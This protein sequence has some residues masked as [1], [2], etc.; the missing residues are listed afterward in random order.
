MSN[1]KT[2]NSK[3]LEEVIS[4][5]KEF[6]SYYKKGNSFLADLW[7]TSESIISLA[8]KMSRDK[9][10][11]SSTNMF[12]SVMKKQR[13]IGISE[14]STEFNNLETGEK[15]IEFTSDKP[16][17]KEEIEKKFS[18]DNITTKLSN[19]WNK[20]IGEGKYRVS[21]FIKVITLDSS[22]ELQK[23]TIL[24]ELFQYSPVVPKIKHE[25]GKYALE[26]SI[27]DAHFGKMAWDKESGESYDLEIAEERYT[28]AINYILSMVDHKTIDEII[29]PIGNDMI[30]IDSRNNETFA[31]TRQDSDSRFFK[32]IQTVKAILVKTINQL[33]EIAPVKVIV[34]S[35]N[36]DPE[37]MFMLGEIMDAYYHNDKN[38]EVNNSPK[39]RKYYQ[40]GSCGFQ[41]THGNEEKHESLGLIFAT[42]ESKLWADTKY[43]F[44]K[45]GHFH[46][47][48]KLN[49]VSIDEHQ[50]FQVQI[51]P[52]LSGSDAWHFS[53]GYNSMKQAKGFLYD[54]HQGEIAQ[55]TFN[56]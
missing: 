14:K 44:C 1:S 41:Y 45:L 22:N 23:E 9:D 4:K 26:I 27:P 16:L 15:N 31:G 35:G 5:L 24:K 19:Y 43:R 18:V 20:E 17:S 39:L 25:H 30:N 28:N 29:F 8:R 12:H 36:H 10:N 3:T 53:K 55:Y 7:G 34:V 11:I 52:S 46:K 56:V 50:G 54:K 48:K 32:I 13:S 2:P 37:S 21:A 42:E 49:Y 51:L 40:Y 38:V 6:P 47:N 33:K